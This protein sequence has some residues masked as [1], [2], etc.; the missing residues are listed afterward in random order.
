MQFSNLVILDPI[1]GI[2]AGLVIA[3]WSVGLIIESR[4]QLLD[5]D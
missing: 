2:V 3:R 1:I 5:I 4:N